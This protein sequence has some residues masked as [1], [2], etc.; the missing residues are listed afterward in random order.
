MFFIVS[1]QWVTSQF[2]KT[3]VVVDGY[4]LL[5]EYAL[6][7]G[8]GQWSEFYPLSPAQNRNLFGAMEG[9]SHQGRKEHAV[10]PHEAEGSVSISLHYEDTYTVRSIL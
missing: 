10:L 2:L 5:I 1:S 3:V 9:K 8:L 7:T 6:W 4:I